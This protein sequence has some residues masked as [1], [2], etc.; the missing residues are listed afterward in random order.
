MVFRSR[1]A[2][3]DFLKIVRKYRHYFPSGFVS[4]FT[5]TERE[6]KVILDM[7]LYIGISG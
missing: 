2:E 1:N 5:G 3:D 6:L 7:G 4:S